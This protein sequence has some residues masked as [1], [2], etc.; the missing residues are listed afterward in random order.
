[1]RA[2]AEALLLHRRPQ[3]PLHHVMAAKYEIVH[4]RPYTQ[5]RSTATTNVKCRLHCQTLGTKTTNHHRP[6][7][8]THIC[9]ST[10]LSSSQSKLP[11]NGRT[12]FTLRSFSP[13]HCEPRDQAMP[14]NWLPTPESSHSAIVLSDVLCRAYILR[15][16]APNFAS[17]HTGWYGMTTKELGFKLFLLW[18]G[19][20]GLSLSRMPLTMCP[21]AL[22][23]NDSQNHVVQRSL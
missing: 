7:P 18:H 4:I 13:R 17:T 12:L 22:L 2:F 21:G 14:L 1:M 3:S 20:K 16:T 6:P 23:L 11:R 19:A 8:T 5:E 9:Q 15:R 10:M